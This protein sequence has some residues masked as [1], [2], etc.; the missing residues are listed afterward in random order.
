MNIDEIV[1]KINTCIAE[2]RHEIAR[3]EERIESLEEAKKALI[4]PDGA[5]WT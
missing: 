4:K 5:V 1:E 2:T 3:L